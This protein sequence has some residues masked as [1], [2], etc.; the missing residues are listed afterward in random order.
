MSNLTMAVMLEGLAEALR[1]K[2]QP[3]LAGD[4]YAAEQ[5]R[6][7]CVLLT[8][9]AQQVDGLAAVRVSE[10]SRMRALLGEAAPTVGG[11][12]GARLAQEERRTE[13]GYRISELDAEGARLRGLMVELHATLE[14]RSD[15]AA[16]A[17]HRRIWSLLQAMDEGRG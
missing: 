5:V 8:I 4:A 13:P 11:D 16:T 9:A 3:A 14:P 15:A 12:L 6:L 7:S 2:V 10:N 1:D 17:M